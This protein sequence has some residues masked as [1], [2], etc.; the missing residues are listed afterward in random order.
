MP[1]QVIKS[2]ANPNLRFLAP[3]QLD[4]YFC[5]LMSIRRA[6]QAHT[7]RLQC[8]NIRLRL[9]LLWAVFMCSL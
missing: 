3:I 2:L 1:I 9:E 8:D 7:Y 4:D 6:F 5:E